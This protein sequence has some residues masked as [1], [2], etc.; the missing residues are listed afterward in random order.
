MLPAIL[1]PYVRMAAFKNKR[2]RNLARDFLKR[3]IT[4]L[5]RAQEEHRKKEEEERQRQKA[6]KTATRRQDDVPAKKKK[7][8]TTSGL[9]S[10]F[11]RQADDSDESDK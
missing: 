4:T 1:H 6:A 5:A 10:A 9:M 7:I 3:E 11:L 2:L 8:N